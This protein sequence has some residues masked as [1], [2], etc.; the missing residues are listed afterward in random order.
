M[1]VLDTNI[2]SE[3]RKKSTGRA[4]AGVV[5]FVER[6]DPALFYLSVVTITELEI[7]VRLLMRR[8]E[9]QAKQLRFWLDNDVAM[10]FTG[11]ILPVDERV[12]VECA[13]LHVPD[14]RPDRDAYIEA[15]A[16]VHKMQ[17]VTRN[18][19]DFRQVKVLN[20]FKD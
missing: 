19:A 7:G 2:V 5:D 6:F 12:A 4:N 15:T 11:R 1:F 16:L 20:P 17:L 8:D 14:P 18:V 13:K 3:L 9:R 10:T